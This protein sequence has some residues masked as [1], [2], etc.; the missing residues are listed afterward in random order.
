MESTSNF[1]TKGYEF[2]PSTSMWRVGLK[3]TETSTVFETEVAFNLKA[4]GALGGL[5]ARNRFGDGFMTDLRTLQ[6]A[7]CE[8]MG[9]TIPSPEDRLLFM[10]RMQDAILLMDSKEHIQRSTMSRLCFIVFYSLKVA[11]ACQM[12]QP[13]YAVMFFNEHILS[14]KYKTPMQNLLTKSH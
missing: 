14:Y 9:Y 7:M 10:T 4:Y 3:A 8:P 6:M 11:A 1:V 2:D 12:S 13:D 5:V